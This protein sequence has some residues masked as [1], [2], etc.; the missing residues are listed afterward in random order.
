[1]GVGGGGGHSCDGWW[2]VPELR[3]GDE[4]DAPDDGPDPTE[5]EDDH[6]GKL[7]EAD[8][9]VDAEGG[10]LGVAVGVWVGGAA[11]S[12]EAGDDGAKPGDA[13]VH[14]AQNDCHCGVH[15]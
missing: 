4:H 2:V 14:N 6:G 8:P 5:E 1:M 10:N 11:E 12:Q 3:L 15:C 9:E 13:D 7:Q